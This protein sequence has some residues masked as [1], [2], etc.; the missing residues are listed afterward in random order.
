MEKNL[1]IT[2]ETSLQQTFLP[3]PWPFLFIEVPLYVTQIF[4]IDNS[5]L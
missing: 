4:L 5:E 1:H 2:M 3:V